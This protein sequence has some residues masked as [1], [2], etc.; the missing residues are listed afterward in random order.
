[1]L[2]LISRSLEKDDRF[3]KVIKLRESMDNIL[4]AYRIY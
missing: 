1:M 2:I 3:L 4:K